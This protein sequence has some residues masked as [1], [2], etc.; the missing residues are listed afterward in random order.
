MILDPVF[1]AVLSGAFSL[2]FAS[3]ALHKWRD[4]RRFGEVFAAYGL[5]PAAL[6]PLSV[7]VPA[8]ESA[9]ALGLLIGPLRRSACAAAMLLLASYAAAVAINLRRGRRDLACGCGGPYDPRPIAGYMVWRNVAL[10]VLLGAS[11]APWTARPLQPV[12]WA[13]IVFGIA[14][15]SVIYVCVDRLG[16]VMRQSRLLRGLP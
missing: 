15:A 9:T 8:L 6:A 3:A 5:V 16:Q 10:I 13:S 11:L 4:V 12:D 2:L 1:G 14:A 7:L